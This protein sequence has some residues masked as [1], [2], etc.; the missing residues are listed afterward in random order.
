MT[1][2]TNLLQGIEMSAA[3]ASTLDISFEV[4]GG[5]L[6]RQIHHWSAAYLYGSIVVH[7]MRVYFT[8]AF[9]KPREFNWIIG[10][11][12]LTLG[13]VEGF[14]VTHSQMI[15]F[16][17]LV[18]VSHKRLFKHYP[19]LVLISHSLPS[20]VHSRVKLSFREF[21]SCTY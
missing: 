9:R 2:A 15:Y 21:T 18:F 6:M 17:E 16:Q 1:E 20:V 10:V 14:L 3:Y 7:L 13:I 4:R 11:G 12:L 8:G 19:S 5:L